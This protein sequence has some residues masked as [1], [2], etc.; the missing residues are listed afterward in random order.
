M[1]QFLV[2]TGNSCETGTNQT[3]GKLSKMRTKHDG[4]IQHHK[5]EVPLDRGPAPTGGRVRGRPGGPHPEHV[6]SPDAGCQQI[7]PDP[8]API[9]SKQGSRASGRMFVSGGPAPAMDQGQG[10]H[11]MDHQ[12]QPT[13]CPDQSDP[14]SRLTVWPPQEQSPGRRITD[15]GGP[16]GPPS[17]G[18]DVHHWGLGRM[19]VNTDC[20]PWMVGK[21]GRNRSECITFWQGTRGIRGRSDFIPCSLPLC[22]EQYAL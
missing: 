21:R 7:E 22:A 13:R 17:R 3:T 6:C 14:S 19:F 16:G 12:R 9:P 20:S 11:Y 18:F 5:G 10:E 1:S 8:A 15:H 4:G 2:K